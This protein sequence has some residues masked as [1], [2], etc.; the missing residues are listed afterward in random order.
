MPIRAA[1]A[2]RLPACKNAFAKICD[3]KN[4][5]AIKT[6]AYD[7]I[8]APYYFGLYQKLK[9]YSILSIYKPFKKGKS[10][11]NLMATEIYHV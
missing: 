8:S 10:P 4:I 1:F 6:D 7:F 11:P 9:I 2:K 5:P 3:E